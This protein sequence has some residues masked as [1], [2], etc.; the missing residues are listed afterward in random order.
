[1]HC[2]KKPQPHPKACHAVHIAKLDSPV[3]TE[4]PHNLTAKRG[5]ML[6]SHDLRR[7]VQNEK[8]TQKHSSHGM[9][10]GDNER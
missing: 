4:N 6:N 7:N 9:N 5:F 10:N 8:E 2:K 1:M 3:T